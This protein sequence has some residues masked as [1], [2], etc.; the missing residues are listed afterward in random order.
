MSDN[1]DEHSFAAAIPPFALP[2]KQRMLLLDRDVAGLDRAQLGAPNPPGSWLNVVQPVSRIAA[3]AVV[4]TPLFLSVDVVSAAVGVLNVVLL[5]LVCRYSLRRL[6]Q[7]SWPVLV[8]IPFSAISMALYGKPEGHAYFTWGWIHIT[9]NS[10]QLALAISLRIL[11]VALPAVLLIR[12][13][14]PTE[15]GDGLAQCWKLPARFVLGAVAG[16]RLASLFAKDWQG[17]ARSRRARGLGENN[18]IAKFF[19]MLFALLVIALRRGG[20]LATAM[21]ARGFG[22][23]PQRTWGRQATLT[24]RDWRLIGLCA[25]MSTG[26]ILVAVF[27]GSFRFLGA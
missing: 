21:E 5:A 2:A 10:L 16:F 17:L 15:L 23:Y 18:K 3:L 22:A 9:D 4:T 6:L 27:T 7:Q 20:K 13:I 11:A 8:A 12:D 26:A 14:N 1:H 25:A 19:T 24:W